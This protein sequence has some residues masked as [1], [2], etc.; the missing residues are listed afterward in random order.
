MLHLRIQNLN[1]IN[2]PVE[3]N[4]G[5]EV[6]L[7]VDYDGTVPISLSQWSVNPIVVIKLANSQQDCHGEKISSDTL[8]EGRNKHQLHKGSLMA[9]DLH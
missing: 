4:P 6:V 8:Y 7:S 1:V 5:N 2:N 3:E 9:H